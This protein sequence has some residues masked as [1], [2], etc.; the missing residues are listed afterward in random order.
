MAR[1]TREEIQQMIDECVEGAVLLTE[2]EG[3]FVTSLSMHMVSGG[4]VTDAMAQRVRE[5]YYAMQGRAYG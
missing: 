4:L 3:G 1:L 5:I 2:A